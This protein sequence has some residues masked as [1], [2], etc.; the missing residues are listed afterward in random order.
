[1]Y[2]VGSIDNACGSAAVSSFGFFLSSP[3][4]WLRDSTKVSIS[5]TKMLLDR[6]LQLNKKGAT[7]MYRICNN[8]GVC[9]EW[10]WHI[11]FSAKFSRHIFFAVFANCP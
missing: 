8:A 9:K 1:M 4:E 6:D 7:I 3:L 5:L 2:L 11:P 10:P